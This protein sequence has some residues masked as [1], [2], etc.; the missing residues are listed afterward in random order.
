MKILKESKKEK[1]PEIKKKSEKLIEIFDKNLTQISEK[2]VDKN[3]DEFEGLCSFQ[4][5][6]RKIVDG[7]RF[8]LLLMDEIENF[9]LHWRSQNNKK[10]TV[11]VFVF[12]SLTKGSIT[13]Y[14]IHYL[15][16]GKY[17]NDRNNWIKYGD[18]YTDRNE[19]LQIAAD[20]ANEKK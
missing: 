3:F 9:P 7:I 15:K 16:M 13:K 14:E 18:T 4:P 8:I 12:N 10:K 17:P 5:T 1:A 11:T 2:P 20:I 6:G 19:A